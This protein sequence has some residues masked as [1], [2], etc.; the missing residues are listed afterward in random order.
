[1]SRISPALRRQ[2]LCPARNCSG[3]LT[4]T[5]QLALYR[6][7]PGQDAVRYRDEPD[8]LSPCDRVLA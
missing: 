1:M 3:L 4:L 5:Y 2:Q 6:M 7:C 8:G